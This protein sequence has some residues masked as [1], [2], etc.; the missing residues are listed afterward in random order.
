MS[1]TQPVSDVLAGPGGTTPVSRPRR[2][3]RIAWMPHVAL[4]PS[5]IIAI[6]AYLGTMAATVEL[7]FTRSKL[8]PVFEFV[9]WHQYVRLFRSDVWLISVGNLLLFGVL[10]VVGC[11][12]IGSVLAIL[13]DRRMRG[14]GLLRTI[15][16]YPYALSFIVTGIVW[17]WILDPTLGIGRSF[18]AMGLPGLAIN[19]LGSEQL[20][21]YAVVVSGIWQSAGLVMALMLAGLRGVD[22]E[23]WKAARVDGIPVWRT[24]VSIIIPQ[25]WPMVITSIVLLAMSVVKSYDLIVA[26][27]NGGPGVSTDVP[28]KF[29]ID[30]LFVRTNVALAMAASTVM[31]VV[32]VVVLMPW[33]YFQYMRKPGGGR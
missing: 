16:L 32:V 15:F 22:G 19:W 11:L 2:G 8:L 33:I 26:L 13:L 14:E 20:A 9:G 25:T 30:Y 27:T 23:I 1:A 3:R 10:Y 6:V 12:V 28:A 5:W 4:T 31:L 21:I 24:Y 7:S 18:A 17:R 29:I